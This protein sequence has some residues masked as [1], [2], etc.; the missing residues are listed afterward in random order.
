MILDITMYIAFIR[1]VNDEVISL[2]IENVARN[3]IYKVNTEIAIKRRTAMI[4]FN[5]GK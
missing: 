4:K 2:K 1:L 3:E 5:A